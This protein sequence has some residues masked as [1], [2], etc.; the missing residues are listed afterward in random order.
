MTEVAVAKI[1]INGLQSRVELWTNKNA[2][3]KGGHSLFLAVTFISW[4][5]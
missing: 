1:L 3:Q 2:R 4:H 5:R